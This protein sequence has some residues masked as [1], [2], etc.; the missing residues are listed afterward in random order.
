MLGWQMRLSEEWEEHQNRVLLLLL[1]NR[2]RGCSVEWRTEPEEMSLWGAEG[3]S[4]GLK[5]ETGCLVFK[6]K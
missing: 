1:F 2:T 4:W 5:G 3:H 6:K